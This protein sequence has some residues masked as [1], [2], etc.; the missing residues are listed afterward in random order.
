MK[1]IRLLFLSA[2]MGLS[3][4]SCEKDP[5]DSEPTPQGGVLQGTLSQNTVVP[6]G[7][8]W[9]L[10]GYVYV[11][12]GITLT[13]GEG[14]TIKSDL[15][16]KGALCIERGGKIF[17]NGT[18]EKPIVFTSGR[19]DTEKAPG[20]W[21]GI[22]ILGKATT[23][24]TEPTIEGGVGRAYGGNDD[25]DN[26]GILKYVR[27]EYAGIAAF[28]NSE[29]NAFTFAGVGRGTTVE[30]CQSYYANDDAFEF[31]GGTVNCKYL[32]A[33]GT[34]D[35]DYDFDF[36]YTG[37]IQY[38]ISKRDPSFVDG[39]DAGNGIE[40]DNDATGSSATPITKPN[41]LNFT[42]MGP[43]SSSSLSNHNLAM[44]W[45][46]NTNFSV[47]N[48]IF[49]GYMKG[50]FSIESDGTAQSFIS[51][52]SIMSTSYI[53]SYDTTNLVKSNST[54]LTKSNMA[55]E[56]ISQGSILSV[57]QVKPFDDNFQTIGTL[58]N[59]QWGAIPSGSYNWTVGW[60]RF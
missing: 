7:S 29:I 17:A 37:T 54:L 60:T 48:S 14:A 40:C 58:V 13:I 46:R 57:S 5:I 35:D 4:S 3:L 38:A 50:G 27:V 42:L 49:Y 16:E 52:S 30:Y 36:G 6:A 1:K 33:V 45:R 55:L 22:I 8:T 28:P 47:Q 32:I 10:K 25:N 41:L 23:N 43:N 2:L 9:T 34:S 12:D 51:G 19:P 11:P 44:R 15:A 24:K 56:V 21:G 20:D 18:A 53:S 39:A 26:S 31:F 59:G